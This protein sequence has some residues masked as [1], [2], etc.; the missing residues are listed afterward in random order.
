MIQR[1]E[2]TLKASNQ[3]RVFR[4]PVQIGRSANCNIVIND[5]A[6][7]K[8]ILSLDKN[9]EGDFFIKDQDGNN[10]SIEILDKIG[11]GVGDLAEKKPVRKS[12]PFNKIIDL[13]QNIIK[14]VFSKKVPTLL[15]PKF[16][17]L[18][19]LLILLLVSLPVIKNMINKPGTTADVSH[20][21]VKMDFNSINSLNLG[22][23]KNVE[24]RKKE[25]ILQVI[26]PKSMESE[27]LLF[28]FEGAGLD[29]GNEISVFI[30]KNLVYNYQVRK[31]CHKTFCHIT[32]DIPAEYTIPGTN[33]VTIKHAYPTSPYLLRNFLL[34][35]MPKATQENMIA[36]EYLFA[37]AERYYKDR[38][39]APENLKTSHQTISK[40]IAMTKEVKFSKELQFKINM[41]QQKIKDE[42]KTI[43]K[44]LNDEI[45]I[46]LKLKKYDKAKYELEK[47]LRYYPESYWKKRNQIIDTIKLVD[48]LIKGS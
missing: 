14:R 4:L 11:I 17:P 37:L 1:V 44:S 43:T 47:L 7:D 10:V 46:L 22:Y 12:G 26:L 31:E 29:K 15:A 18:R 8:M 20:K 13:E 2:I 16:M 32:M 30:N 42:F 3:S 38:E 28:S 9:S 35:F 40:A 5:N 27:A 19:I 6:L 33:T 21:A 23:S 36:L 25:I 48:K 24:F 41:L 39:L 34:K 45:S